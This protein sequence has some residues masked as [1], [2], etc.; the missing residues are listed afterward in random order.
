MNKKRIVLLVVISLIFLT[1]VISAMSI[2]YF[3]SSTCSV[4]NSIKPLIVD[5][6][7]EFNYNHNWN[8]FDVS[9]GSSGMSAVPTI[10]ITTSDCREIE[11]V[12]T[13][14]INKYLKCELQEMSSLECMTHSE[15]N[16]G[17][18]FIE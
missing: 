16:R 17:S 10:K 1:S 4:C 6:S 14:E 5:L 8:F 7:S 18:Y 11:L 2:N 12:G 9:R 13:Q 15:L 3:Y